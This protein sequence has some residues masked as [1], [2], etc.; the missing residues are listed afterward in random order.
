MQKQRLQRVVLAAAVA[1][2]SLVPTASIA[3][4]TA[5]DNSKTNTRDRSKDELT[6]GQQKE[7]ATD[8][9]SSTATSACVTLE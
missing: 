8:R 1:G 2:L 9:S 3:A 4:Q 7:N 5:P 6:A